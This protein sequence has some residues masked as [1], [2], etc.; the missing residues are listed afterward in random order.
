M[1]GLAADRPLKSNFLPGLLEGLLGSLGIAAPREGNPPTSSREGA[2]QAWSTAVQEAISQIEQKEVEAP[3]A[4][5]LP[6]NLN[7]RYQENFLEKQRHLVPPVFLDQLFIPKMAKAVFGMVKPL[8]VLKA[9]P[10]ASRREVPSAPHQPGDGGLKL[11]VPKLEESIPSTSQ[12]PLQVQEQSSGASDTDSGKTDEPIPEER[13]SRRSL[14]VK[15]PLG[16]LKCSHKAT[17]SS[18]KDGATPSKVLK[19]LEA[20]EAET[21]AS[22]GPSE[23]ALR[24]ARFE[25]Y[26]K[27]LPGKSRKSMPRSSVPRRGRRSLKRL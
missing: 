4:V 17:T 21:T 11:E 18:P 3:G 24:K 9:L 13:Q 15:L 26:K 20:E 16:L 22:A 23:A 12:T 2:G 10:P 8:V 5:G 14:K 1:V 6:P 27:D 25:L 7:L 19:E